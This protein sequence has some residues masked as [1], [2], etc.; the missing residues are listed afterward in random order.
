MLFLSIYV[1]L[2]KIA[3]CAGVLL[4]YWFLVLVLNGGYPLGSSGSIVL[5]GS[6]WRVVVVNK[7][8]KIEIKNFT[9]PKMYAVQNNSMLNGL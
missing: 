3:M 1:N 8:N 4:M 2:S 9:F 5:C 6:F 7:P